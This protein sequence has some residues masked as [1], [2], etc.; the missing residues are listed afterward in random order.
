VVLVPRQRPPELDSLLAQ[1]AGIAATQQVGAVRAAAG[2]DGGGGLGGGEQHVLH[3]ER[4]QVAG[5]RRRGSRPV[6]GDL[7]WRGQGQMAGVRIAFSGSFSRN[8]FSLPISALFITRVDY[9]FYSLLSR[10]A[11]DV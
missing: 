6:G 4:G 8:R 11:E 7:A 10:Q 3:P 5:R 2:G 9:H 1:G